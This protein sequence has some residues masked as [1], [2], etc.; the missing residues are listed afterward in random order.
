M[1][2]FVIKLLW[3]RRTSTGSHKMARRMLVSP[4]GSA[5]I[6]LNLYGQ[7]MLLFLG[8]G[9]RIFYITKKTNKKKKKNNKQYHAFSV[10]TET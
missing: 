2:C 7:G 1:S 4:G 10:T 8:M 9:G 3:N 5:P 6:A